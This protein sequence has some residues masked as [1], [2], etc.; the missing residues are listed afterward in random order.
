MVAKNV[1]EARVRAELAESNIEITDM[2]STPAPFNILLWRV[3][4]KTPDD[5]YYEVITGFLD[6]KPGERIR[7]PLNSK[8]AHALTDNPMLDGLRWFS[9]D[10]LRYDE[11]DNQLVATDLRMGLG[12]GY[13]SFRFKV[14][15]RDPV[16]GQW[17]TTPPE[18]WRSER[19]VDALGNVLTRIIHQSPPLPL[20]S[21]ETRMT[22]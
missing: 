14:A 13:Y 16:T 12:T 8:P 10:W 2:F 18:R 5:H 1:T 3:M 9:G 7:L 17:R 4:A 20:A 15:Q 22:R 19:G 6:D 21:W 11:I